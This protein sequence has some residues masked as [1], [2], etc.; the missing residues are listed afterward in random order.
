MA[1]IA[2]DIR[3]NTS[4]ALGE[5]KKLSRELDNKFLV[6]GLK[7]DV[8]KNAFRQI[9]KE[10][11][12]AVGTQGIKASESTAQLQRALGLQL[13]TLKKFGE[14][15][16][17][18]VAASLIGLLSD[19]EAKGEITSK[20]FRESLD[21][22][23]LL[24][25]EGASEER[26]RGFENATK[27]IALFVQKSNDLF[28]GDQGALIKKGIS[29]ELRYEDLLNFDLSSSGAAG[30][31]FK[32]AL[33]EYAA[34]IQSVDPTDRVEGFLSVIRKLQ[35]DKEY[36]QAFRD[37][38]PITQLFRE[39]QGL[40]QPQRG[41][42]GALR[43]IGPEIKNINEESVDR[44][45]LQLTGKLLNT[46]FN[47][48]K[49]LFASLFNVL[50]DVFGLGDPLNVILT[51]VEFFT[52]ILEKV[53]DFVES[54][55][56]RNF[57]T[58]FTPIVD[59]IKSI[60]PEN[61]SFDIRSINDFIN[62][63]GEGIRAFINKV[64]EYISNLDTG[65]I[66]SILANILSEIA[67]TIPSLIGLILTSLGK[68]IGAAFDTFLKADGGGKLLIA[69]GALVLFRKQIFAAISGLVGAV[70]GLFNVRGGIGNLLDRGRAPGS[71]RLGNAL[72]GFE[73]QV[74][75]KLDTIIRILGGG[76][77][78]GDSPGGRPGRPGRPGR[79]SAAAQQR[80]RRRFGNR[81]FRSRFRSPVRGGARFRLARRGLTGLGRNIAGAFAATRPQ[82]SQF[83]AGFGT[84]ANTARG[85][86]VAVGA[87]S[88]GRA[89]N[90]GQGLRNL[91][92]TISKSFSG[93]VT[94]LS[95]A[96]DKIALISRNIAS[97]SSSLFRSASRNIR[98][99]S[100]LASSSLTS[101]FRSSTAS[102]TSLSSRASRG[103]TSLFSRAPQL[104]ANAGP[105]LSTGTNRIVTAFRG[106]SSRITDLLARGG[107][108]ISSVG[109]TARAGLNNLFASTSASLSRSFNTLF[110]KTSAS[111]SSSF[112]SLSTRVSS[113][114]QRGTGSLTSI[115]R[116]VST[117]I[118]SIFTSAANGLRSISTTAT[119]ATT[120]VAKR[121]PQIAS[122]AAQATRSFA[123][124]IASRGGSLLRGAG[125]GFGRLGGPLLA[126]LLGGFAIADILGNDVK[127]EELEGLTPEERK[128]RLKQ[129]ERGKTRGILGVLGGIGGGAL[130]GAG[131]GAALGAAGA[132][133]FTVAVGGILGSIVGGIIG[134]EAVRALG[135]NIIDGVTDFAKN[136]GG[137]FSDTWGSISG[138]WNT[139]TGAIGDFF[140]KD[141]PI[142]R[143]G[144]FAGGNLQGGIENVN[145]FFGEEGPIQT[146][147]GFVTSLPG[148]I[149]EN[150]KTSFD[151]IKEKFTELPGQIWD[152][153]SAGF[154]SLFGLEKK[155]PLDQRFLGG[156]GSGMT[157][158]GE[159][160]PELVNLGSGSVVTPMTSFAGLGLSGSSS[161][162]QSVNN[163]VI[164]VNAPGA[165]EF[166]DQLSVQVIEKLDELFEEQKASQGK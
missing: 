121:V 45:L 160:G 95:G 142:Q 32:A 43:A 122:K 89:F 162:A 91:P 41:L 104:A 156:V 81:A 11:D 131:V 19:L 106:V 128:A 149:V 40:F 61:I 38:A 28:G 14:T 141:G 133:P 54:P 23:A 123:G 125:R 52:S 105:A 12:T 34:Q 88:P 55:A 5:F 111:L 80:F 76:G 96:G 7:L 118:G 166:A 82:F 164:N 13:N 86:N 69:G 71:S 100:S 154:G 165:D 98:S 42:F 37:V 10:F 159:N 27:E 94:K 1:N 22:A 139:A 25:F 74:L 58:V 117:R 102:I 136:I 124:G 87:G 99:I 119:R 138:G 59:A 126:T 77:L 8:V 63:L 48:E 84:T 132:N 152:S 158:V 109:R 73:G 150:I 134:E 24:D 33:R 67:K 31:A 49:G 56:F 85:F 72:R 35:Q 129:N 18:E 30:N 135:D 97:E 147:F 60:D 161:A 140:G 120:E 53:Q 79:T 92:S 83:R 148:E 75:L 108:S 145:D 143:F 66:S 39:L 9:T 101:L 151:T 47:R 127:G 93:V 130:A 137:W 21:I 153:L 15:A 146:V 144:R 65:S 50:N 57:L 62:G 70:T 163:V 113:L 20:T 17:Q 26:K 115:S 107:R 16:R 68:L 64:T 110:T 116:V 90:I 36:K 3:A 44:N 6:Q 46:I 103:I 112:N 157:L 4:K 2:L 155:D 114:L 78:P 29:G 51:G